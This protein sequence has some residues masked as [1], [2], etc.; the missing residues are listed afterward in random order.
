MAGRL[1]DRV[2]VVTG[3]GQ[4]IGGGIA[5]RLA[6]EGCRIVVAEWN[7]DTGPLTVKDIEE[8]GGEGLFV[9]TDVSDKEQAQACGL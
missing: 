7:S 6:R 8:R 4:G 9:K 3:A 2:A 1:Q 5:R